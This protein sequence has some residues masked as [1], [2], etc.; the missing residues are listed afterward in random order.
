[1]TRFLQA[2]AFLTVLP[3]PRARVV[4]QAPEPWAAAWFPAV[5]AALGAGLLGFH[6]VLVGVFPALVAAALT[7]AV[8]LGMTGCL[9]MDGLM[10]SADALLGHRTPEDRLR[11]LKDPAVGAF[12]V[13][14]GCIVL[15]VKAGALA[16]LSRHSR[17]ALL[18]APIL[19]RWSVLVTMMT[20]RYHQRP[21]R[22]TGSTLTARLGVRQLAVATI[23]PLLVALLIGPLALGG[24]VL[25]G[26]VALAIGA[27]ASRRIPA[28]TGDIYGLVIEIVEAMTLCL[29][30]TSFAS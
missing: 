24:L 25:A 22:T 29:F 10:D 12:G 27:F 13:A 3:I 28:L 4:A 7:L 6:T 5:G 1:M 17:I 11:I 19:A 16:S 14:A 23:L 26:P 9:H 18:I 2:L 20:F 8:W 21:E 30:S 15:L